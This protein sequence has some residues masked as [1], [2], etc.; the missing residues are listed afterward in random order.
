M[1]AD[2]RSRAQ[3]RRDPIARAAAYT[4]RT[5]AK[6]QLVTRLLPARWIKRLR[7][8]TCVNVSARVPVEAVAVVFVGACF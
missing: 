3:R 1:S 4:Q 6:R 5:G 8:G 2:P 7:E